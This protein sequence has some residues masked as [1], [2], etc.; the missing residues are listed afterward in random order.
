MILVCA[1]YLHLFRWNP[2]PL[3]S[4]VSP[5]SVATCVPLCT[6]ALYVLHPRPISVPHASSLV[7]FSPSCVLPAHLTVYRT[8][9]LMPRSRYLAAMSATSLFVLYYSDSPLATHAYCVPRARV[10]SC[11]FLTNPFVTYLVRYCALTQPFPWLT[12]L[13]ARPYDSTLVYLYI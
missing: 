6:D 12:D 8:Y 1:R 3:A 2:N 11:S 10:I 9:R 4:T 13:Y 5:F 7:P